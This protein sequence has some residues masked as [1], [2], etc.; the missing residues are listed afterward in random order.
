MKDMNDIPRTC[1]MQ[2]IRQASRM[3]T[4][5]Y[6]D[7]LRPFDLTASQFSALVAVATARGAPIGVLADH[8]GM[9][10]TTL[11]RVLAPLERRGLVVMRQDDTDRRSRVPDLTEAGR[12]LLAEAATAWRQAQEATLKR[13]GGEWPSVRDTLAKLK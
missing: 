7:R 8:L 12:T 10:R 4:A 1:V 6:E 5:I 2:A 11:T 3:V 9:D 13:L